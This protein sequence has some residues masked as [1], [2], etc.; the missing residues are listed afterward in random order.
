MRASAPISVS[1]D[2][3][4]TERKDTPR[5]PACRARAYQSIKRRES[6]AHTLKG[7]KRAPHM[8]SDMPRS[9]SCA[10]FAH[11]R[12][13]LCSQRVSNSLHSLPSPPSTRGSTRRWLAAPCG[14][15]LPCGMPC[16]HGMHVP[17]TWAS[18]WPD[19]YRYHGRSCPWHSRASARSSRLVDRTLTTLAVLFRALLWRGRRTCW[20]RCC[21]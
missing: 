8:L 2:R 19:S 12:P 1:A 7:N 16:M 4:R 3:G 9:R 18:E 10:R 5:G 6:T 11:A 17:V 13:R 15:H 14:F 20:C 21:D